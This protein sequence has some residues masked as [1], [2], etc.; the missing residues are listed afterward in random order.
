MLVLTPTAFSLK[1]WEILIGN[2]KL[3]PEIQSAIRSAGSKGFLVLAG[4]QLGLPVSRSSCE[5]FVRVTMRKRDLT[6]TIEYMDPKAYL[7]KAPL[8]LPQWVS[9]ADQWYIKVLMF[10]IRKVRLLQ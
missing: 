2:I 5:D 6:P 3:I 4:W 10:T 9:E 1:K 7:S 8:G